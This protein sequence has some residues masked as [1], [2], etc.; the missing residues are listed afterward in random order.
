MWMRPVVP[1]NPSENEAH[2]LP[3]SHPD[4]GRHR[5]HWQPRN[6]TGNL[7]ISCHHVE[8]HA[9]CPARSSMSPPWWPDEPQLPY[10]PYR[11]SYRRG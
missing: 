9:A 2:V 6:T 1:E 8:A 3:A 4:G 7:R 10:R 5:L 11:H